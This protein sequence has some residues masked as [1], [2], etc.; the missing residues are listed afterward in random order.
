MKLPY[1][2]LKDALDEARDSFS[3]GGSSDKV[4]SVAK[5]LGKSVAN[6]GMLAAE[7]GVEVVKRA[8]EIVGSVAKRNLDQKSHLMSD[9]QIENSRALVI[10][11][12]EARKARLEKER[13]HMKD[14]EN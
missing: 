9:E 5:L 6:V 4:A 14:K 12:E 11:G 3:Y 7:A 8:P 1:F 13:E 10:K 2:K